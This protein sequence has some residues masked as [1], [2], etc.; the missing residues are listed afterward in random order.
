MIS[1]IHHIIIHTAYCVHNWCPLRPPC[2]MKNFLYTSHEKRHSAL[3]AAD[4]LGLL[5]STT[6]YTH[7]IHIHNFHYVHANV[8]SWHLSL[9]LNISLHTTQ[10]Y[11]HSS[12]CISLHLFR[13]QCYLKDL[14]QTPSEY[15]QSPLHMCWCSLRVLC[16]VNDLLHTSQEYGCSPLCMCWWC[17]RLVH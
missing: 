2:W 12:V 14:L 9:L 15:G 6:S 17:F 5:S 3:C 4:D 8:P 1:N 16:W 13:T 7:H 11:W 10:E